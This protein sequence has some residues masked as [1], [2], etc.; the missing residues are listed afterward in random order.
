MEN[1]ASQASVTEDQYPAPTL[2]V[3]KNKGRGLLRRKSTRRKQNDRA[4]EQE[5]LN[6]SSQP[7]YSNLS[8]ALASRPSGDMPSD[9]RSFKVSA[10]DA[11]TPRPVLQCA[12]DSGHTPA[13]S[14]NISSCSTTRNARPMAPFVAT[15][16]I[17]NLVDNMNSSELR[18]LLERDHRRSMRSR[19]AEEF[20]NRRLQ[21]VHGGHEASAGGA[22]H[23]KPTA[24]S[25]NNSGSWLKDPSKEN[26]APKELSSADNQIVAPPSREQPPPVPI[27]AFVPV[28]SHLPPTPA[29]STSDVSRS[30]YDEKRNSGT[31]LTRSLAGIFRRASS[32]MKRHPQ[33]TQSSFSIP[34]R[35]SF[36]KSHSVRAAQPRDIPPKPA[37]LRAAPSNHSSSRF[38]EH[39]DDFP[40]SMA[41]T[42]REGPAAVDDGYSASRRVSTI[43]RYSVSFVSTTDV[44]DERATRAHSPD[45]NADPL[46]LAQ[47][48]ASI[49]SEG[50]WLSG[51]PSRRLSQAHRNNLRKSASSTKER[52]DESAESGE[53]DDSAEDNIFGRFSILEE[54]N[55]QAGGSKN[56]DLS[57]SAR[58]DSEVIEQAPDDETKTFHAGVGKRPIV[59]RPK[60][61]AKSTEGLFTAYQGSTAE[62]YTPEDPN[63]PVEIQRATSVD[64]GKGKGHARHISAGSARLLDLPSPRI[65]SQNP[66]AEVAVESIASAEEKSDADVNKE[67][68]KWT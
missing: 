10:F 24:A 37:L 48:F 13:T 50:S 52:L 55:E 23:D 29:M 4:R 46:M 41:N 56:S 3:K 66:E 33:P 68:M 51:K 1:N 19:G 42:R 64:L 62:F 26:L 21:Q 65:A 43:D 54:E 20:L 18:A 47:S 31:Q 40:T 17:D 27:K 8:A 28:A 22:Q 45:C 2:A 57:P 16:R 14:R 36:V 61:G 11:I 39:L 12:E 67:E 9:G 53:Y 7:V 63:T 34:S 32:R 58:P 30:L 44:L 38:T 25:N 15:D 49:D 35:E 59:V 5:I 60:S 6:M